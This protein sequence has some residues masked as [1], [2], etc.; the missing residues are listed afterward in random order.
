MDGLDGEGGAIDLT[1]EQLRGVIQAQ[2][3]YDEPCRGCGPWVHACKLAYALHRENVII[4]VA[5]TSYIGTML[6]Q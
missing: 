1:S 3:S 2:D 5:E 6:G 4:Q